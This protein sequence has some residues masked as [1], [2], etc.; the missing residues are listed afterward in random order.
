MAAKGNKNAVGNKG[1]APTKYKP[2][3]AE[4]AYK[5]CL[6]GATNDELADFFEV[7]P[8]TID[9]WIADLPEF[10]GS[11]KKG[12]AEADSNV[13]NRLYQRAMGYEHSEDKIFNH[14]GQPLIVPTRKYYP[15]DSTAAIFWLK[16]RKPAQWRDKQDVEHS[17]GLTVEIVRF[18]DKDT[19]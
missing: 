4:Q 5:L 18:A 9:K 8:S 16:N 6:L 10:S 14:N 3:Y 17:G 15:P 11:I 12:K 7:D 19:E 1:G 13:A 2:E